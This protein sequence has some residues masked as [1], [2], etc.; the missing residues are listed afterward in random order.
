MA[1]QY[2]SILK[3]ALPTQ[4]ELSGTWGDVVNDNITSMV[5]EAIAGRS[6]INSWAANSH[7]LTTADGLT[8]ESR[9]AM[10]EFTDTGTALSG[11][12]TVICPT[13]TK[14]YVC[15]NGAGQTVTVKT[16]AGT[17]VAIPNGETMFVFCDG[18]NVVQAVTS[19]TTL[20]V[21][22]GI[23]VSTILDEDNM[24]SDSATALATQQSI[25]AYVDAQIT[26]QDLDF[27]GDTGTGA[28]DLDSQTFTV[29][30]TANE[31]ETSASGQTITIGL[32][33]AIVVTT[34]TTTNVQATNIKANDGTAA[35][36]IADSTGQVTVADAVLTTADINGGT[37]DNVTIGG[38]TAAAGSFTTLGASGTTT[39]SGALALTGNLDIN[40]NKFNVTAVDGNTLIAGTLGVTGNVD[41]NGGAIDGTVIGGSTAA[42]VTGTTIVANTSIEIA[43]TTTVSSILDEDNMASD[44]D[45]AL[46]TQQS[47]K[48]YVD[49]QVGT[50]DT[51]AE[52]LA[53]GNTSGA[54]DLVIDSGQVLTTNTINETTAA[55]G[56]TI[57]S[58][59]LKDD[60]VNATNLEITNLK[61]NDGTSAGSIADSTGVVTLASSVLTT[62]D[63]NA[64]TIDG[65]VIGGSTAAAGTFTTGAF[66]GDTTIGAATAATNVQLT[67][68]GVANKAK[69]IKF[70]ESG[71]D[72]WIIGQ[73]AA[74][75]TDAFEIYNTNGQ[76]SLSIAKATSA[77]AFSGN[78]GIGISTP[79]THLHVQGSSG[80][81][82]VQDTGSGGGIVSFRDNGTSS[83]PS[84]QSSGNNLLVNTG[85]A[86]RMRIDS[87]GNVGIGVSPSSW[88]TTSNRR[89]L[90][91]GFLGNGLYS[92]GS[93][94]INMSGAAYFDGV[95]KYASTGVLP[96]YYNQSSGNHSWS[97]ASSGTAGGAISWSEAMRINSSGNVGIGTT[98]PQEK[99]HSVGR[100]LST[101]QYGASTQ[102][103]GTSIGENGNTRADIDFRRWTGAA[104]NHGVGMIEVADTGV[105]AFYTDTKTS[106]TPATTERMRIDA[107]GNVG[108][109][110]T[111]PSTF[112]KL[113]VTGSTPFAVLRSSDVTTAGFSM[114]VNGGS[115]GVGSIA[116]DDGGHL[117][118][119][120]GSTGA[121]QAERMRID[122]SGNLG[123]G[124]TPSAWNSGYKA[125]QF[126]TG[127]LYGTSSRDTNLGANVFVNAGG[128]YAYIQS[129]F[130]T[131]Y[132]QF[133]GVHSWFNAP[134]GT[135][136]NAIS[137]TQAMTLDASGNL[138]V[139]TTSAFGT[140]GTTINPAGLI[141]SSADGDRSG[142]FD[143][144]GVSDGEIVRFTK[145]G[146]TVGSIGV[147]SGD[148]LYIGGSVASHSGLYFGTNTAAPIT[149]GTLTD[150]V[151]DLG[152]A[153]YR[154]KDLYLSGG[155]VFGA[156]G[157]S[158]SSKTLDDYEE[159]TWTPTLEG[160]TS[161][162]TTTYTDQSGN[163]TKI[164]N[165]V[166][167]GFYISFTAATG[168]GEM[169]LGGLPFTQNAVNTN[170]VKL[171]GVMTDGL[172]WDVDGSLILMGTINTTYMRLGISRDD[173][174]IHI[175]GVTN[176][177][178]TIWGSL[179]Y[180]TNS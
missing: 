179:T 56:V 12:A 164:G 78:V 157:G 123:L 5:E 96:T 36:T 113:V 13:A 79:D 146:S 162:G 180:I 134:S 116:T 135:A 68:N 155:V 117:T 101:T 29:A 37:A 23:Q 141:Y 9:A 90:E 32:P 172:N 39:L 27:A 102:R 21:G 41:L 4:G 73:G 104:A 128:G 87:A 74:S 158:V 163:Y 85:G 84:I 119:D 171:G 6:V 149:A 132:T 60:G 106:N 59:L 42:A 15:K 140:T 136:G 22:T 48:A 43:G 25:K 169:K 114:L 121:G 173:T 95:W 28:V 152:T 58:V 127:A 153:G 69:R 133:N 165:T 174:A 145:A 138:L 8:S 52:I 131:N 38:S 50:V 130:A 177:T 83:I 168:T 143:R 170:N 161:A 72:K 45:T 71:V 31:I 178:A 175:Q 54:T 80:E 112:G 47:I 103:I 19:L 76:M 81:I 120:T 35:I 176:E 11:A 99:T 88:Q 40:T 67:L 150:A 125:M 10:L 97:T 14:I 86:E 17:G 160:T 166:I 109:G 44:S 34:I 18:T 46:A 144:T 62:T 111:S 53:N 2:T 92:Y 75:E 142:Q 77:A 167:I 61:A 126:L 105:M 55:S 64:G 154:F 147:D 139:G 7:T 1:T 107:S 70:A 26:A 100:I 93:G 63:I 65:T 94:N 115:N 57:D 110:E 51:L 122:S 156:T 137:F 124:V 49:S 108:I 24:A 98:T 3:L 148:N 89:G 20:K 66:S 151:T 129:S 82:R 30:G 33:T 118:F 16:A 91:L 159:G